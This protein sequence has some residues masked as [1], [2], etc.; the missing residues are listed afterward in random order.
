MKKEE[1][2]K[3]VLNINLGQNTLKKMPQVESPVNSL[4]VRNVQQRIHVLG[5]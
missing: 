3:N 5:Y 2:A 4:D 1:P